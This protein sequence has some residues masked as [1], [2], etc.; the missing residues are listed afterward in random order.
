MNSYG[1][2]TTT[3]SPG[4][5]CFSSRPRNYRLTLICHPC[6]RLGGAAVRLLPWSRL[7]ELVL[8]RDLYSRFQNKSCIASSTDSRASQPIFE[9]DVVMPASERSRR[10]RDGFLGSSSKCLR[11]CHHDDESDNGSLLH[12]PGD[13]IQIVACRI[14]MCQAIYSLDNSDSTLCKTS[15]YWISQGRGKP[16]GSAAPVWPQ[17]TRPS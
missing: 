2:A 15:H 8:V 3:Y 10:V 13:S 16:L 4:H 11:A 6:Y 5:Y 1:R 14:F 12:S 7:V 17:P 9:C